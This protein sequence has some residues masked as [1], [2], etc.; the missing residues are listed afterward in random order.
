MQ[1]AIVPVYERKDDVD[2]LKDVH[3]F[4]TC[5]NRSKGTMT[6]KLDGHPVF[7]INQFGVR[8]NER[9]AFV[10]NEKGKKTPLR[11]PTRYKILDHGGTD[12]LITPINIQS[13]ISFFTLL[14]AYRPN[15]R[16]G[17][18]NADTQGLV[19]LESSQFRFPG[20]FFYYNPLTFDPIHGGPEATFVQDSPLDATGLQHIPTIPWQFRLFGQGAEL[21]LFSY[22]VLIR[23]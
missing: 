8:L 9:N 5:Y 17:K 14:D 6:W 12:E 2:P 19:R 18:N 20:I 15:N 1:R 23:L 21:R 3:E 13:G 16:K 22:E 4:E 10:F 11:N 7:Q